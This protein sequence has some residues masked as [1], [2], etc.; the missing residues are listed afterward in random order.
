MPLPAAVQA[1]VDRANALLREGGKK[2]PDLK[3]ASP[4]PAPAPAAT[5]DPETLK[6]QLAEANER[7]AKETQ[8]ANTADGIAKKSAAEAKAAKDK[9]DAKEKEEKEATERARKALESG[10]VEGLTEEDRR[11]V[12]KDLLGVV[13]KAAR[14]VV[15]TEIQGAMKPWTER[16]EFL[17]RVTDEAYVMMIGVIP[18]FDA[19]NNDPKFIAWLN[20]P[21][22]ASG[23]LRMS[24]VRRAEEARQP[25]LVIEIFAAFREGREIGVPKP[26]VATSGP[27]AIVDAGTGGG[28]EVVL[29]KTA[30]G[31]KIWSRA[32]IKN[33]YDEKRRGL[34]R[35][36][37][38]EARKLELDL[39]AAYGEGRI[40]DR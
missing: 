20:Q 26:G 10:D 6:R 15:R 1:R 5:D 25:H 13:V 31:K 14:H 8:R 11:L 39:S 33:F 36:K 12:G 7:L 23:Q 2:G 30:D 37:E 16:V 28:N 29:D 4:A 24:I 34:W 3:V 18:N 32:E 40:R 21:D 38:E 17:D 19:Q 35:G 27:G 9:L 22:P